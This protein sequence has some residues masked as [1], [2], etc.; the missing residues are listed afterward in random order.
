MINN[1]HYL[2]HLLLTSKYKFLFTLFLYSLI[3]FLYNS[4]NE[5]YCIEEKK[6]NIIISDTSSEEYI[7]SEK[8][9]G[10]S[11]FVTSVFF[12]LFLQYT[13][14]TFD[15]GSV[16]EVASEIINSPVI[17][18]VGSVISEV[19]TPVVVELPSCLD[20]FQINDVGDVLIN[21]VQVNLDNLYLNASK[22]E[23]EIINNILKNQV[24]DYKAFHLVTALAEAKC[25]DPVYLSLYE[26]FL[27]KGNRPEEFYNYIAKALRLNR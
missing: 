2:A 3:I 15:P 16:V 19:E 22:V 13:T 12:M 17:S 27:E 11:M 21:G 20:N 18:E 7:L 1:I 14:N 5:V 4:N 6:E 8:L 10:Y 26:D 25:I 24:A 23:E 9:I